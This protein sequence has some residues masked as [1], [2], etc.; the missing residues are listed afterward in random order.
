VRGVPCAMPRLAKSGAKH[1]RH[2]AAAYAA[3]VC[4]MK[5][6]SFRSTTRRPP[7]C[8]RRYAI[9]PAGALYVAAG[10]PVERQ[11]LIHARRGAIHA[12]AHAM[13]C[14]RCPLPS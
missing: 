10:L 5:R 7:R 11:L 8:Q 4:R 6:V 1:R 12:A 2:A 9:P 3:D 13:P 14:R